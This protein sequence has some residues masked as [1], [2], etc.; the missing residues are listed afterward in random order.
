MTKLRTRYSRLT[1]N[2]SQNKAPPSKDQRKNALLG[3]V[4]MTS[5]SSSGTNLNLVGLENELRW[6][7]S[8]KSCN[9]L[10]MFP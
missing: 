2:V 3:I 7:W 4:P 5:F 6:P 1:K 10:T 9:R 8:R